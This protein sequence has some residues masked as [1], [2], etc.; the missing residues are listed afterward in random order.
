ML[1]LLL[2]RRPRRHDHIAENQIW[3]EPTESAEEAAM[4]LAGAGIAATDTAEAV[5]MEKAVEHYRERSLDVALEQ[6][7]WWAEEEAAE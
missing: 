2:R 7:S 4:D 5:T 3:T 1:E 6:L